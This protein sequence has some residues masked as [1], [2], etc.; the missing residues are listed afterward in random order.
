[1]VLLDKISF[2]DVPGIPKSVR[3]EKIW[4][5]PS[6]VQAELG[7]TSLHKILAGRAVAIEAPAGFGKTTLSKIIAV[8]LARDFLKE[9]CSSSQ[10]WQSLHL[11]VNAGEHGHFPILTDLRFVEKFDE[12][13]S[14]IRYA[15]PTVRDADMRHFA[16]LLESGSVVFVLDG[17][18]EIEPAR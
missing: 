10:S 9:P 18:D 12:I 17:L 2:L 15:S 6:F 5:R 3:L 8:S 1:Q 4:I 16:S 14:L 13:E 11:G 7:L